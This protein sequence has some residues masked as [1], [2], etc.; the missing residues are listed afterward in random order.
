MKILTDKIIQPY[1]T[2]KSSKRQEKLNE[3]ALIVDPSLTK[4]DVKEAVRK[5]FGLEP[6]S[7]RTIVFRKKFRR[8]RFGEVTPKSYKKAL[9]RLPEGK[10]LEL[11]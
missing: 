2:E 8:T 4:S 11:K 7:I 6:L 5:I 1:L 3:F 10:R 9:I